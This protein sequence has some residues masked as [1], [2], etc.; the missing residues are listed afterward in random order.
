MN[1]VIRLEC[2][3]HMQAEQ[4]FQTQLFRLLAISTLIVGAAIY[5]G[6]SALSHSRQAVVVKDQ[7]MSPMEFR[8]FV[9]TRINGAR[10]IEEL[11]TSFDPFEFTVIAL[12]DGRILCN[13]EIP[14]A[15]PTSM[16]Y[17]AVLK[18]KDGG[19]GIVKTEVMGKGP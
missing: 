17:N 19:F 1:I 2:D 14:A 12:D 10:T 13:R 9:E 11:Q 18:P 5:A 4:K 15:F 7:H 3:K 6:C 16:W 8:T